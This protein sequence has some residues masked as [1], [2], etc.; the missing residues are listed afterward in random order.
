MPK[1]CKAAL[2]VLLQLAQK[3]SWSVLGLWNDLSYWGVIYRLRRL[4]LLGSLARVMMDTAECLA[5]TL[6]LDVC[7]RHLVSSVDTW[8]RVPARSLETSLSLPRRRWLDIYQ[9]VGESV[10]HVGGC[11]R[12]GVRAWRAWGVRLG[13]CG[14]VTIAGCWG[15]IG[16]RGAA[17]MRDECGVRA[18][19]SDEWHVHELTPLPQL[20]QA[21]APPWLVATTPPNTSLGGPMKTPSPV[22]GFLQQRYH[23]GLV[24]S[25]LNCKNLKVCRTAYH[26]HH[27]LYCFTSKDIVYLPP[28]TNFLNLF[29]I[30]NIKKL[31]S[32]S[33]LENF[34]FK[35]I[36]WAEKDIHYIHWKA[37]QK[38]SFS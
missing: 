25:K 4:C 17:W 33:L 20:L 24:S 5:T 9:R 32:R 13:K 11:L 35:V 31:A 27:R 16:G 30:S 38:P 22:Q 23:S 18:E 7:N 19:G 1:I 14:A 15:G 12:C 37:F 3:D 28:M 6:R 29:R 21:E 34:T 2:H 36:Q 26:Y 10:S 8:H